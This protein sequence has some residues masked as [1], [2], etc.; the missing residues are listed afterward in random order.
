MRLS[1]GITGHR[2]TNSAYNANETQI[3]ATLQKLL[4]AIDT[5]SDGRLKPR[6]HA[7][8]ALGTDIMAME[9]ADGLG[10]QLA[11]P[12]PFGRK[13]NIAVNAHPTTVEEAAALLR[14]SSDCS[15]VASENAH[16]IG[17][18]ADKVICMELAERDDEI[19]ALFL[20]SLNDPPQVDKIQDFTV[21]AS[22]RAA[23]AGKVMIEQ[24]DLL[25]AVWDGHSSGPTGGTR[26]TM[27]AA[28]ETGIPVLWID[29]G[30]PSDWRLLDTP[31]AIANRWQIAVISDMDAL[32]ALFSGLL[33]NDDTG[34]G[35]NL[36]ETAKIPH[37]S[38]MRFHT[39]RQIETLFAGAPS[40]VF[41]SHRQ[42]YV[43][44]DILLEKQANAVFNS[45]RKLPGVD[46]RLL[47]E[48]ENKVIRR[49][50]RAD[51]LATYLSDAYRGGMVANLLLAAFAVIGGIA[52]LPF[53]DAAFKWPFALLEF[54][55]LS[56]I[57]LV[58]AVGRKK[59]W[60]GRWFQTR[61]VAEYLRHAPFMLFL[62]VAR[63]SGSWPHSSDTAWPEV[64][65]KS[66]LR[67]IGL[68]NAVI[69][70]QML[71]AS[72]EHWIGTHVSAQRQY[73][74][75]KAERLG[76]IDHNLEKISE[77]LFL[78]A[79][80]VVAAYLMAEIA[81]A[82]GLVASETV[83][84]YSKLFTFFGVALPTLGGALAGIHYF[85]DFGRF[86]AISESTA[87]RLE[88]VER[89][90]QALLAAPSH[91]LDYGRVASITHMVD[92]IVVSEIEHWQDVFGG[93]HISVP[94]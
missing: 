27:F 29:A 45:A 77:R 64:Y 35:E 70:Q 65:V 76:R 83:R 8:L 94:V 24:V 23:L 80:F 62:G 63:P 10:W 2:N 60:H 30:N 25:L 87:G 38:A 93:K 54:A 4:G 42:D 11:S 90:I 44:E 15:S 69:G 88:A 58:I 21:A 59:E 14:G 31:E 34:T 7:L 72:L 51:A 46:I 78:L 37:R 48:T 41:G 91:E 49:F 66:I 40:A 32:P 47:E 92:E 53:V 56:I 9:I 52:Y 6:L 74:I 55:L 57:L 13:L 26:H 5:I 86:A 89:R 22:Q 61:R 68:P 67:E 28:L 81:A 1:M 43:S 84:H 20:A 75:G 85:A 79:M 82:I 17:K 12:L 16:R 33:P 39:Y 50:A 18:I 71:R 73:H 36:L 3:L 19:E